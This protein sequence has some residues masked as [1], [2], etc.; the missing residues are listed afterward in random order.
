MKPFSVRIVHPH[1]FH[2]G[3]DQR[4]LVFR[5][6]RRVSTEESIIAYEVVPWD[7]CQDFLFCDDARWVKRIDFSLRQKLFNPIPN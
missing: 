7:G 3:L 6:T 2:M 4:D 1:E 5:A